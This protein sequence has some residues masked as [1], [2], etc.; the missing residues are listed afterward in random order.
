MAVCAVAQLERA[1]ALNFEQI[2]SIVQRL[3]L[4]GQRVFDPTFP[5]FVLVKLALGVWGGVS[6]LLALK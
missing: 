2:N 5:H 1:Q 3:R 4:T 6:E